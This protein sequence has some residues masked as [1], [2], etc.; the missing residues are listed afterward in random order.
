[1]KPD[2]VVFRGGGKVMEITLI[3]HEK[4]LLTE[5]DRITSF[6]FT[7]WVEKYDKQG[8]CEETNFPYETVARI[9]KTNI[10]MI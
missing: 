10:M 4:S 6:A 7:S 8:V 2:V 3:R 1:M 5:N 9:A